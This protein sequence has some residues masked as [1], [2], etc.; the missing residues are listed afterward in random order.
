M[1]DVGQRE[2]FTQQRVLRFFHESLGYAY[3]GNRKDRDDNGN[4][5]KALLTGWLQRQGYG[6]KLIAKALRELDQAAALSGSKTLYDANREV[7]G[8]LR[9]GVKVRPDVGEQ[10]VTVWLIDWKN[11]E[12]N[13]FA[14]AEEVTIAG[15]HAKRPDV[16]LYVNGIALGM[17]ELKRSTV[18]VTEG[19]RQNLDSQKKEFI[20]PFYATVQLVMA[21]NDTEGLRYGVIETPE[22][23]W[24][25]WKEQSPDWTPRTSSDIKY[26]SPWDDGSITRLDYQ[27]GWICSKDRLLEILHDFIVFD[28]G[29]KKTCRHNQYFG[30]RAA[31]N[32]VKRREGGILWHTQGSGKS[33]TMVWLAKWIREHV[34]DGR[35]LLITDRTELDEQIEKVFNG[36][37]ENIYRTRSGA[38]LVRVLNTGEEWLICSLIHKFGAGEDISDKDID[39]YVDEIRKSLPN[40]FRAKGEIF[41]FV[42]ECHRTQSGKLHEAMKILLPGAMLIGFTGTPLL[43]KDKQKSIEVFGPYIH[44]YKYHEAVRDGVVLDL[45]YEARDIDQNITSQEKVDQWFEIKTRGLSD[46]ARAQLKQR[47]GTMQK[48]LSSQDRLAKIVADILLDMETRDRLKSGYGNALLVSG[49]IYSACRFFEM[50]QKTDLAGK[51]AIVTSYRPNPGDIKGEESGEGL[52]ERLRQYDIYRKMLAA[53][54]NEPEESAMYKVEQFEQEV[55]K[56]FI[57]LPGQMK[58]LIVVDKLLTG[59]DAPPATY[60]YIDKQMQDHG[61]FQAICRVNRLDGE[62]KEYGY[63]IDYKDLFRSLEKSIRDYTGE[64]FEGYDKEDIAGLL[65]DRLE[66]GHERLEEL[67]EAVKALCEPVEPPRD[68]AAYI[69]FF[70]ATESGNA[71]QLKDNEPK[72]VALYKLVAALLR[73]WANLA[74]EMTE[75]WYSAAEAAEVRAEVDHFEK[76]REEVKLAS[77]DYVDMKLYEPAMRHLLDTYIRAEESEKVSAFD[78]MTLVQLIVERGEAAIE[79]LPEGIRSNPEAMAETIENNVRRLII[80]EMTVNPKYYEKMSQ[81]LD[82]LIRQRKQEALDYKAYLA[83]V[84]ELTRNVSKPESGSIYPVSIN[85]PAR[86][87]LYDNLKGIE[88]LDQL[89]TWRNAVRDCRDPVEE[90][91]LAVDNAIRAVKKDDWRGMRAKRIEVRNA[92]KSV[93]G[94]DDG[95][96]DAIYQI[97]ESQ[98]DY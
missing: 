19:I 58:L 7:Y 51:C 8:L 28:A 37:S 56:R 54:F 84:V 31:Q 67:R 13:D 90:V 26:L 85:S 22:K 79:A 53:H 39:A 95:L 82:A 30:V 45:R 4:V 32:Q 23:Y 21:G 72:R 74:N 11:P 62:D 14:V 15:K 98:R 48:V 34:I 43:K 27:L 36:V 10:N 33:L 96:V 29:I 93:L 18:S 86:R 57:E 92:I 47:W 91:A 17:L 89:A 65:K 41:V 9:Y 71:G 76:V 78:D 24:L 49:S 59:F 16:V 61:L 6:D 44:T 60:L 38:D 5:E 25:E 73:A 66:Q 81:L 88:G 1:S 55:K 70:C 75:A 63:V 87:A 12:N 46:W 94:D 20:R 68:T 50:F 2:V 97:A 35:V 42:D 77:G 52:T 80:D 69:R 64:A 40:G 3:L 83:K